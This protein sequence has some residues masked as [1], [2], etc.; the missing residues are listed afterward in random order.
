MEYLVVPTFVIDNE[1][2]VLVWNRA[3]ERLTGVMAEEVLNTKNHWRAF[4]AEERPCLA[5]LLA[6]GD[7]DGIG[8]LYASWNGFGMSD[9]GVSVENWCVMPKMERQLYLAIDAGPIYDEGGSLIAVVETVRDITAQ[10]E[11][12]RNL[13]QLAAKD[14]LTGLANRR[15]FDEALSSE[16]RRAARD[17]KPLSL[18]MIDVDHFKSFNDHYGHQGGDECLRGVAS[19]IRGALLRAGDL[20]ARYGGEEFAVILPNTDSTSASLIADRIRRMVEGLKVL[21]AGSTTAACL[22]V[23]VGGVTGKSSDLDAT[24]LLAAAD[25]ALYASKRDGRN[26]VTMAEAEPSLILF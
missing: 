1:S 9:F 11:A 20:P 10:H 18:L 23:S 6:R 17:D 14:G 8:T 4:Y 12:Q 3:C 21:H 19:A 24:R 15:S 13:E 22:T 2:R 7:Y 26:R 5:D 16:V 25:T